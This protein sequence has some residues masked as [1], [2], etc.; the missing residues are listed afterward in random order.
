MST[1]TSPSSKVISKEKPMPNIYDCIVIGGGPAGM[2]AA[3]NLLRGGKSVLVIE[4]EAFGGQIATSPRV[5]NIPSI[6]EISGLEFSN[7]LFEQ[8]SDLGVEFELEDVERIEKKGDLFTLVTNYGT[9]QSKT[10]IIATGVIHVHIG[11][12]REKELVGK[13]VSYCATCDGAFFKDKDVVV[14][15]DA[16][17][18]AQYTLLLANYC[19]HVTVCT[20]F[21]HYF[22]D[23]ILVDRIKANPK[24][25]TIHEL[26]LQQFLGDDQLEGLRFKNTKTGEDVFVKC[27][28]VFI[29]IGQ[30]AD[31]N[32]F[33]NVVKLDERG[34]ILVDEKM[35]T[36][37]PG[38]FAIGDCTKKELRQVQTAC[39]DGAI[40]AFNILKQF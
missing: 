25:N 29:C 32:R 17:T 13:G 28:G 20:L 34:F 10:V 36:S 3:L 19:H 12:D 22:A 31:N 33:E 38:L 11:V 39:N 1:I 27:D 9:H 26:S 35:Q 2:T 15:G 4:R 21:D 16:N 5:E 6:K 30:K 7:N 23:K 14:I 40:A 8:I 18:A 37:T 24:I